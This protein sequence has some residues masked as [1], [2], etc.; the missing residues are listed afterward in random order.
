MTTGAI[1]VAP[2]S[3]AGVM[4]PGDP[5]RGRVGAVCA[6]TTRHR[7]CPYRSQAIHPEDRGRRGP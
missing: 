2:G 7:G 3:L 5:R 1:R 6:V 4:G